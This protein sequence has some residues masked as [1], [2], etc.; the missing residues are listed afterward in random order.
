[1][2]DREKLPSKRQPPKLLSEQEA[3]DLLAQA[4][5]LWADLQANNLGGFSGI[6]RPFYIL[7][8][9]KRVIEKFG[10]RDVGLRWSKNDLDAAAAAALDAPSG[11]VDAVSV[12][13]AIGE[14]AH[15][16][17]GVTPAMRELMQLRRDNLREIADTL[18]EVEPAIQAA[19][20]AGIN[21]GLD[22]AAKVAARW[23]KFR[24][25][26]TDIDDARDVSAQIAQAIRSMK[27]R[28]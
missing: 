3:A 4:E 26:G 17:T 2:T 24:W 21:E 6:N 23:D 28:T 22:M 12:A 20:Q 16:R 11:D 5:A 9:F 25:N 19:R 15:K 1:M 10:G 27:D 13:F 18:S 7:H 14:E 8:E